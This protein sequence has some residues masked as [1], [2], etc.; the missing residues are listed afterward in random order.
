LFANYLHHLAEPSLNRHKT[1]RIDFKGVFFIYIKL[2]G[3]NNIKVNV[4]KKKKVQTS[5]FMQYAIKRRKT[6]NKYQN[7]MQKYYAK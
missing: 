5:S 6:L 2:L 4:D 1:L 3:C 7:L